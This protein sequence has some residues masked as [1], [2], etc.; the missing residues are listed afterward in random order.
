MNI[1]MKDGTAEIKLTVVDAAV[2][3]TPSEGDTYYSPSLDYPDGDP[4][5]IVW[6]GSKGDYGLLLSNRV[7]K[8]EDSAAAQQKALN[9]LLFFILT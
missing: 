7:H 5:E 3:Y 1:E 2:A 8:T 9:Q 4:I 6:T